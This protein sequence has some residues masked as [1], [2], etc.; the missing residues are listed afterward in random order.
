MTNRERGA[1]HVSIYAFIVVLVLLLGVLWFGYIQMTDIKTADADRAKALVAKLELQL[2]LDIY[3]DY[4][5]EIT[6]AVG[7]Q[8]TYTG[9]KNWDYQSKYIDLLPAGTSWNKDTKQIEGIDGANI[10][11]VEGVAMPEPLQEKAKALARA[12]GMPDVTAAPL[13]TFLGTIEVRFKIEQDNVSKADLARIAS[14]QEKAAVESAAQETASS[15]GQANQALGDSFQKAK[16]DLDSG[17]AQ[18]SERLNDLRQELARKNEELDSLR[19]SS[20]DQIV[21][22]NKQIAE[23]RLHLDQVQQKLA[24]LNAPEEAD[25]NI[26]SANM[27]V[28]RAWVGLG[29][30]DM[31]VLG[32]VFRIQTPVAD[33]S[34]PAIKAYGKVIRIEDDRAELQISGLKDRYDPVVKG[35]QVANSLYSPHLKRNIALLGRFGY[36]Y[37]KPEVK[38]LLER[39]GNKVYD[40]VGVG[41]DLVIVGGDTIGEEGDFETITKDPGYVFAQEHRIEIVPMNKIRD[42]LI[43]SDS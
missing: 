2:E 27:S 8:G 15:L 11:K 18:Q 23:L 17:M 30:K 41:V 7:E 13:S 10:L 20:N 19:T 21:A 1:S 38:T 5:K 42:L 24:L 40:K 12:L 29:R 39:L 22:R 35:D 14:I 31:L 36:P 28:N 33:G 4:V 37:P 3:K 32:L 26:L 6:A 9:K 16:A 43:L 34:E 25:G